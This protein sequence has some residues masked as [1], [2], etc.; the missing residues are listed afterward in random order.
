M[1]VGF[2][3]ADEHLLLFTF[4]YCGK[5]PSVILTVYE[6]FFIFKSLAIVS[7]SLHETTVLSSCTFFR[8][9]GLKPITSELSQQECCA[10]SST[11]GESAS[12]PREDT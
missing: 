10:A 4:C 11:F 6:V 2:S 5:N 3:R 12:K 9:R 8:D 1:G 7:L